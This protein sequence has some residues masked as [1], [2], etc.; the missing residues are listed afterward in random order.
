MLTLQ[1]EGAFAPHRLG[2]WEVPKRH[3]TRPRARSGA[4]R[5][6]SDERGHLLP[7]YRKL[8][9]TPWGIGPFTAWDHPNKITRSFAHVPLPQQE[10]PP[11]P[12]H[13]EHGQ[14]EIKSTF[15][16]EATKRRSLS[17]SSRAKKAEVRSE[18]LV[19][20]SRS[21]Q[22]G[23]P[24]TPN[25][26]RE[27]RR[28]S[29]ASS[30][31]APPPPQPPESLSEIRAPDR[32][33]LPPSSRRSSASM[34]PHTA[35]APP[36]PSVISDVSQSGPALGMGY[37]AFQV[38]RALA[39]DSRTHQPLPDTVHDPLFC[40]LQARRDRDPGLALPSP[41]TQPQLPATPPRP[42]SSGPPPRRITEMDLA[43]RWDLRLPG[44]KRKNVSGPRVAPAVFNVVPP[45]D[46]DCGL[47]GGCNTP[48]PQ[49]RMAWSEQPAHAIEKPRINPDPP[50][51]NAPRRQDTPPVAPR[52]S[53]S[54]PNLSRR[55][56]AA[57]DDHK[58]PATAPT[59][60]SR[61]TNNNYKQAFKAGR[62]NN[63]RPYTAL[64]K[65]LIVPQPRKPFSKRSYSIATLAPPFSLW[66]D[67]SRAQDYPD[68]WRLAS[69][70]Q[71]A[72]K[73]PQL[74]RKPLLASVFQ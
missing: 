61:S 45:I 59:Q 71:H 2:N 19:A 49:P 74:R 43:I 56:C 11:T 33:S 42:A 66:P 4:T 72:Y 54:T 25:K 6:V 12:V 60:P 16:P 44:E 53:R 55:V 46:G 7:G 67:G 17:A 21:S 37:S 23:K 62:P 39:E 58:K 26:V 1:Y 27:T 65:P 24:E 68:H 51:N 18:G 48:P 9:D 32:S 13:S 40:A 47:P 5:P 15:R 36:A 8:G 50:Q 29:A 64:P 52:R 34:R 31:C 28:S 69:V 22:D 38:A 57:C 10:A 73:P 3:P 14:H 20:S 35:P 41:G 30:T 63:S 70:Y